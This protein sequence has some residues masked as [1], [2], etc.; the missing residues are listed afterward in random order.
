MRH[1]AAPIMLHGA[2]DELRHERRRLRRHAHL[3]EVQE[4]PRV[5][6]QRLPV[7]QPIE[8]TRCHD[9]TAD[10]RS[11]HNERLALA[12]DRTGKAIKEKRVR[13]WR[14]GEASSDQWRGLGGQKMS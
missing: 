7:S 11:M 1:L 10:R 4:G 5:R 13:P 2:R 12:R 3:R 8:S 6:Q 14:P 9:R